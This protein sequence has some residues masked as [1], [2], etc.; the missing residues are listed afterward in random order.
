MYGFIETQS[1]GYPVE[2]VCGALAVNP[3]GYYAWRVRPESERAQSNEALRARIDAAWIASRKT[4]GS[5]RMTAQLQDEGVPCSENRVARVMAESDL[6]ARKTK[7]FTAQTT[8]SNHCLPIAPNHLDQDFSA[9]APNQKWV[10]DITYIPTQQGWLYLAVWMDLFSRMIVG[11]SMGSRCDAKLVVDALEMAQANR[12]AAP[13][14]LAHSDRGSQ[15]ASAEHREVLLAW[16]FLQSMSRKGNCYDNA[17]MESF[18]STLKIELV[19][20]QEVYLTRD[21]ARASLIDY[22]EVFYNRQRIHTSLGN[23]SPAKFEAV[24][25]LS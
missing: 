11:W 24:F 10:G 1:A 8:D 17:A 20:A 15:Y 9:T 4:Y 13:G 2:V 18:F 22:I 16:G 3:S 21:I 25:G 14:L 7:A 19:Y 12:G 6:K 5:P 23:K